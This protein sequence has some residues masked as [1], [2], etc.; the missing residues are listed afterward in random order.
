[1]LKNINLVNKESAIELLEYIRNKP[2]LDAD[3]RIRN[4]HITELNVY[5]G[6]YLKKMLYTL[7]PK[8]Y[9]KL[10]SLLVNINVIIITD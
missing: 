9:G 5:L 10:C 6:K 4:S 1:M 3:I 8:H 2:N 7:I